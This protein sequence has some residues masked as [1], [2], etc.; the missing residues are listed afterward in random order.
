MINEIGPLT[1][2]EPETCPLLVPVTADRLWMYPISAYCR[3]PHHRVRVPAAATLARVC[4]R[5]GY[6][7]CAG[8]RAS[9]RQLVVQADVVERLWSGARGRGAEPRSSKQ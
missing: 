5:P 1:A 7:E 8:Y 9:I 6:R 4:M 3:W 2:R